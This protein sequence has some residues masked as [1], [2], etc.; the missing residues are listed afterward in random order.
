[1]FVRTDQPDETTTTYLKDHPFDV[2]QQAYRSKSADDAQI[3]DWAK[4]A[5]RY[6]DLFSLRRPVIPSGVMAAQH[7]LKLLE[8]GR[9]FD[10]SHRCAC[11]LLAIRNCNEALKN[12]PNSAGAYRL[13][14][15]TYLR[16]G[17]METAI[18]SQ[19]GMRI[20]N[21]L[22]YFQSITALQ[23]AVALEPEDTD[24]IEL[25]V[26]QYGT[27]GRSDMQLE[28]CQRLKQQFPFT[29]SMSDE[30]REKRE[31]IIGAISQLEEPIE[32]INN[33]VTKALDENVDRLQI[34][35]ARIERGGLLKSIKIT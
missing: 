7:D 15:L 4:P 28:L 18:L 24:V 9:G 27:V 26:Q 25:L 11:A 29:K 35:M 31:R 19:G 30:K 12:E 10:M 6:D 34:A 16:I 17:Q 33:M 8:G 13:L 14:G 32:R 1:M 22:R 5:T 2:V 23:Q 20:P 21:T 3:R